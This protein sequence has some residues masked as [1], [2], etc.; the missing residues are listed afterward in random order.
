MVKSRFSRTQ[1]EKQLILVFGDFK[2]L[3]DL[4]RFDRFI[5]SKNYNLRN[6]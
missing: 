2:I 1:L 4:L 3:N 5:L 6:I